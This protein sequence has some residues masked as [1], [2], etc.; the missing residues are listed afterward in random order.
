MNVEHAGRRALHHVEVTAM[1]LRYGDIRF[2]CDD[3][4]RITPGIEDGP[5]RAQDAPRG[6]YGSDQ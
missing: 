4:G 3:E 1:I 2:P 6:R 5:A